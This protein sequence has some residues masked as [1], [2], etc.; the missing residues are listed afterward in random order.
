ML[1]IIDRYLLAEAA[2]FFLA[3]IAVLLLVVASMLF[4]RTLEEVN[5]GALSVH[6]VLRFLGYQIVRDIASVLPP[7]FFLAVLMTLSRLS[8]DSELIA[9]GACGIGPGRQLRTLLLLAL[10]VALCTGWISIGLKP[11][12][13]TGIHQIRLQQQ[14]QGAQIAGLQPGRFY[15]EERGELVL[16][17]GSIDRAQQLGDVF[18]LDRR[19]EI[20]HL[21]ISQGGRHRIEA[22]TGDHIVTLA[23]GHR[24]DG[25]PGTGAFRISEFEEYRVRI[26]AQRP[27]PAVTSKRTALPTTVLVRSPDPGDRAELEHRFAAPL[28]V[29]VLTIVAIPLVTLSPRERGA[30]RLLLALLAYFSFFNLQRLAEGWMAD[31]I[32]P[33]WLTSYWYQALILIIVYLVLLPE[34]LW[35]KRILRWLR[36]RRAVDQSRRALAPSHL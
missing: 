16:Y 24:F 30:G 4:L 26:R 20:E 21:I 8:R 11:W 12:A 14:D 28:A 33:L 31:G 15:V 18:I 1:G 19:D 25:N 6:L 34:S 32:T 10:P 13:A 35:L 29:I 5:V 9:L 23:R 17:I 2:K 27:A 7:A 3:I 22:D 36:P